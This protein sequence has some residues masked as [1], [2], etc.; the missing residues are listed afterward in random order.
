MALG[1]SF[2]IS[3]SGFCVSQAQQVQQQ[4]QNQSRPQNTIYE[5]KATAS[6]LASLPQP[7][8][9]AVTL[10]FSAKLENELASNDSLYW[11]DLV[12][13]LIIKTQAQGFTVSKLTITDNINSYEV[14]IEAIPHYEEEYAPNIFEALMDYILRPVKRL[15]LI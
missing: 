9:P 13:T 5:Y 10:H 1:L 12:D 14:N 8:Q 4:Q 2:L 11:D 6:V 15:I 3:G 7:Q